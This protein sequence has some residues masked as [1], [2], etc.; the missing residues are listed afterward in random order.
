MGVMVRSTA[1]NSEPRG[2][3]AA[4][5]G[6]DLQVA[7]RDRVQDQVLLAGAETRRGK[8]GQGDPGRMER[9][10]LSITPAAATA[11]G[12]SF[13][14]RPSMLSR[15]NCFFRT[16]AQ[17]SASNSASSKTVTRMPAN[18][19]KRLTKRRNSSS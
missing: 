6:H 18:S 14:P 10:Y 2:R 11:A 16:S 8:V 17:S 4:Q 15:W 9:R 5:V 19:G 3:A 7:E 13:S 1:S 12:W